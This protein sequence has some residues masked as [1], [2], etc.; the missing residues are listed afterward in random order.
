MRMRRLLNILKRNFSRFTLHIIQLLSSHFR[1]HIC[2]TKK[3]MKIIRNKNNTLK[4]YF[5]AGLSFHGGEK[6]G[7][8]D[9]SISVNKDDA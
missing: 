1:V 3:Y 6:E 9:E 8:D 4:R 7:D 2:R 5:F